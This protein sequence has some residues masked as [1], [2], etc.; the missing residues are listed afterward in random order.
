MRSACSQEQRWS[1]RASAWLLLLVPLLLALTP[2]GQAQE[3]TAG[4]HILDAAV[5][6]DEAV[7]YRSTA[8]LTP[9]YRRGNTHDSREQSRASWNL[10]RREKTRLHALDELLL[11]HLES[12][13][14]ASTLTLPV[15]SVERIRIGDS[16]EVGEDGSELMRV[17]AIDS[18]N[19]TVTVTERRRAPGERYVAPK[20]WP[21]GTPVFLHRR[22]MPEPLPGY[23]VDSGVRPQYD[24][25]RL[26][27]VG[28]DVPYL[29]INLDFPGGDDELKDWMNL[30]VYVR[31][32]RSDGQGTA[33]EGIL[34]LAADAELPSEIGGPG[35]P[36]TIREQHLRLH[37]GMPNRLDSRPQGALI[38]SHASDVMRDTVLGNYSQRTF[39]HV[40]LDWIYAEYGHDLGRIYSTDDRFN[41]EELEALAGSPETVSEALVRSYQI[42]MDV[43]F[44]DGTDPRIDTASFSILDQPDDTESPEPSDD[45]PATP[46][47]GW[48]KGSDSPNFIAP[49]ALTAQFLDVPSSHDGQTAFTFELRFSEEFP[50]SYR[51]LRDHALA[52]AGGSVQ[53][54]R[55]LERDSDTP[56]LRWEITVSPDGSSEVT[57]QLPGTTDCD[58]AGAICTK[59]G[60]MLSSRLEATVGGPS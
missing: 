52:V 44:L 3:L 8:R 35:D 46:F 22:A 6:E 48:W 54:A 38:V 50:L 32:S 57:I 42:D 31:L 19:T 39:L 40:M 43:A 34:P 33:I 36:Y 14:S 9:V 11:G 5:G 23:M 25:F 53:K 56:N 41:A 4:L 21:E 20:Q 12:A 51:T 13:I 58:V 17:A 18:V 47:P 60:R 1:I 26:S 7:L 24:N 15:P 49:T 37:L 55:R 45:G 29:A 30:L 28:R 27:W 59:D 16:I 2:P 10:V